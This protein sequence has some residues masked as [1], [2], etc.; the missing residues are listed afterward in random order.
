MAGD[1]LLS[2]DEL[3]REAGTTSRN[4]RN[5]QTRGL[6]PAPRMI[7]HTGY[8]DAGHL[9]RLRHIARLQSRGFSLASIGDLLAAWESGRGLSDVLG[10]EEVL[11]EPW[12]TE[13]PEIVDAAELQRLFPETA[14]RPELLAR[15][16]E[17]AVVVP[18]GDRFRLPQPGL[19]RMGAE[20]VASG[21]PLDAILDTLAELRTYA[22]HIAERYVALFEEHLWKPFVARG[23]PPAELATIVETLR[24]LRPFAQ[25]AVQLELGRAMEEHVA[26][27]A[28]AESH[29][30]AELTRRGRS[31]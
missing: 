27:A 4:V 12:T 14:E 10:L 19:I 29:L 5:Y 18:E 9:A 3:A 8:Y 11:T 21:I 17:L 15:A 31:A 24:R 13:V 23:L 28:A 30:L 25:S 20:V 1:A 2:I 22:S 16:V 6:L 7:G 26:G